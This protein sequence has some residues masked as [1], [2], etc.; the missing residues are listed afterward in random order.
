MSCKGVFYLPGTTCIHLCL[1]KCVPQKLRL[2]HPLSESIK[3]K[4]EIYLVCIDISRMCEYCFTLKIFFQKFEAIL[5]VVSRIIA[6]IPMLVF[7]TASAM[8]HETSMA[9]IQRKK[10]KRSLIIWIALTVHKYLNLQTAYF[11]TEVYEILGDVFIADNNVTSVLMCVTSKK[12][13]TF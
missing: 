4:M 12:V 6:K 3:G 2:R 7:L 5:G 13:D 9:L 1:D 8:L 10:W 11:C